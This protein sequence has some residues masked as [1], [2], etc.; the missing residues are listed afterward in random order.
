M[1]S[2]LA[3][4]F[5]CSLV[6]FGI[7]WARVD[8]QRAADQKADGGESRHYDAR[9]AATAGFSVKPRATQLGAVNGLSAQI[10]ELAATYDEKFGVTRT[11]MNNVGFLTLGVTG[12]EPL[13]IAQTFVESNTELLGLSPDDLQNSEVTDVVNNPVSGTHHVYLRQTYQGLPVYNAQLQVNLNQDG[14]LLSVNNQFVPGLAASIN[15]VAPDISAARAVA[16]A[17]ADAK[18]PYRGLPKTL[19]ASFGLSRETAISPDGLSLEPIKA[20]LMYLPVRLGVVRLVWN[21]SVYALD[22]QHWYDFTVDAETGAVWTRFDWV[23]SDQIAAYPRPLESPNHHASIFPPADGRSTLTDAHDAGA[24]SPFGWHDTNGSGGADFTITQ[25]NNAHAYEDINNNNLPDGVVTDCG[26]S[27]FCNF[28]INLAGLPNTYIPASIANLFYWNNIIHD[29]Q[30]RYGFTELGGNFQQNNY[31]RGGVAA[32]YVQA[33]GQDGGGTNNA[34]FGTPPDGTRPRM[35]MYN[36]TLSTPSRD[37]D[38]DAGIVVHEYGH[39]ISNRLVG[40]PSNVSCLTNAQQPGEGLSDW[41]ALAYTAKPAD[42]ALMGRGIGTY[43]LN[44]ATTGAGIR[45]Q[46]YSTDPAINNFTYASINGMVIPH[47]VGSVWAQA[48]WE[49]YWALVTQY[50][51]SADLYNST[52]GAGN[53]RAMQYIN[54]G[55]QNTICSPAFTD[56][57]DGIIQAA[58]TLNGGADVCRVWTAFAQFGLGVNAVSGGSGSTAPTNGFGVPG[59]CIPG[60]APAISIADVSVNEAAASVTFTASITPAPAVGFPATVNFATA[61][62]TAVSTSADTAFNNATAITIPDSGAATPYPSNINVAA[63]PGGVTKVTARLNSFSHTFPADVDVLLVGPTGQRIILMSDVG[64]GVAVSGLNL[65]F[66][67]TGAPV[68]GTLVSGT[69]LPTNAGGADTFPAPA[70]GGPYATTLSAFNFLNPVGN[71][72]LYV[73]DGFAGDVG[74]IAGGWTLTLGT[75][76][77][78]YQYTT[79][80]VTFNPGVTSQP[81]TIPLYGDATVE[82][83]QTFFVN[84]TGAGNATIADAQGIATIID[85][86]GPPPPVPNPMADVAFDFGGTGL[87]GYY[88]NGGAPTWSLLHSF[89]PSQLT[90]ARSTSGNLDGNNNFDLLANFPGYGLWA[91]MNNT[92][93]VQVHPMD[94]SDVETGDLDGN[95]VED[96]IVTFPGLGLWARMNGTTWTQL[97]PFDASPIDTGDINGDGIKDLIV[98][99]PGYGVWT[100]IGGTWAQIHGANVTDI[101]SADMDANGQEDLL[102]NFPGLGIWTRANNGTWGQLHG[103]NPSRIATGNIDGDVAGRADVVLNFPGV[104]VWSFRNNATWSQIHGLNSPVLGIGDVDGNGTDDVLL[105]FAGYGAWVFKNNATFQQLHPLNPEDIAAGRVDNTLRSRSTQP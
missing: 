11:L 36:W 6:L 95:G 42:T 18:L 8:G 92:T 22:A 76:N 73:V 28:A 46:R 77:G 51:F 12:V 65:T 68:P 7:L 58:T 75:P 52:G 29:I 97:H 41:W 50:G 25:G 39:G 45:T 31:G 82:G 38:L 49:V 85:N 53:Q 84:L 48:Y 61:D 2:T 17:A 86:D 44:Q 93:W 40:G 80:T 62:G 102:L 9:I 78:D 55:L 101:Q 59:A 14:R 19:S 37:G 24:A 83:N 32:D 16:N 74:S 94:V 34:N 21:F 71:W 90:I 79:G 27:I 67:D 96:I 57:R 88:N 47:G 13:A 4:G 56:V 99:F 66:A 63:F 43:A 87:W 10:P 89:N 103:L 15:A 54:T 35:Q 81:I 98:N 3:R 69:Y 30:Y 91:R 105:S 1:S 5:A 104:G 60:G 23:A 72:S 64:G 26:P 33:E 70:P 20:K 100:R